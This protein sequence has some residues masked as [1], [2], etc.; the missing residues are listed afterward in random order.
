[1]K[2]PILRSLSALVMALVL[3]A[4]SQ[5]PGAVGIEK[6]R[7]AAMPA[8]ASWAAAQD[9]NGRLK[10][11]HYDDKR[12]LHIVDPVKGTAAQ[13]FHPEGNTRAS[14]GIDIAWLGDEAFVAFRDKEPKRDVFIGN[15]AKPDTLAGVAGDSVPLSRVKLLPSGNGL[16]AIWYGEKNLGQKKYHVNYRQLDAKGQPQGEVQEL[17]EGIYPVAS[18]TPGGRTTALSWHKKDGADVIVARSKTDTQPFGDEV[19]VA[20]SGPLTPL[21]EAISAGERTLAFW[22]AQYGVNLDEF[23]LEGAYSDDGIKWEK[24]HLKGL[25]GMDIESADFAADGQGNVAAVVAAIPSAEFK[26][27]IGKMRAFI[28]LSHDNGVTWSAPTELRQDPL[29]KTSDKVFSHSRAP[30]VV[31]TGPGKLLVAWQDWRDLRSAVHIS[32]SEDGGKS[33]MINDQRFS[34]HGPLLEGL[35]LFSKSLFAHDGTVQMVVERYV[36]DGMSEKRLEV[37][38]LKRDDLVNWKPRQPKHGQPDVAQLE[39]R[40]MDYWAALQARD[41]EKSYS[42]LDPYFRGKVRFDIYKEN[43]GKIEYRNPVLKFKDSYGPLAMAVT[44]MTV[45]VKPITINNKTFKMD[46]AERDIPT[47]WLWVDGAW[48]MEYYQESKEVKYAPF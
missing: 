10:I 4:C 42:L 24:F 35:A 3:A 16:A 32:Y 44:N 5:T 41:F 15:I 25:D 12:Y 2:K 29:Q 48:Y 27:K 47:R 46:P 33:W 34:E 21:F 11:A 20:K 26:A 22:H 40:V 31:F 17:F 30:K 18:V 6:G 19:V 37:R 9:K 23:R 1:M 13:P 43:L 7:T 45:E 8:D 14:S 39:Q 28:L 38:T 36:G